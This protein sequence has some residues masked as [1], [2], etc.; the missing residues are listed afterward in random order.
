MISENC[1]NYFWQV[2]INLSIK[3]A[4][5]LEILRL[6]NFGACFTKRMRKWFYA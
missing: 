3:Y 4:S 1:D 6:L 2:M 5:R